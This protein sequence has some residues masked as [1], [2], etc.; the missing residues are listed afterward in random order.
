MTPHVTHTRVQANGITFH[1]AVSGP[2]AAPPVLCL[3]GFPEGWMSWRPVMKQLGHLRVYAPDM[4]GYGDTDRPSCGYDVESLTDDIRALIEALGLDRPVLVGHD[5]GGELGWIFAHRYSAFISRL[6]VVNGTHPRTLVRAALQVDDLQ[7]FRLAFVPFLAVPWL[8]EHLVA[9]PP[10]RRLLKL[11]FT[12]REGRPG[13]MDTALV[14][15]L[16]ARFHTA[17]EARAPI[18][19]YRELL[20]TLILPGRRKR[21]NAIYDT[22]ITVPITQVWGEEDEALSAEVALKADRDAGR[23][24]EWR[25]LPGVGHFVS[26]EAP[27]K[28][29]REIARVVPR[30]AGSGAGQ[31][32][33]R[34]A[35]VPGRAAS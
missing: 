34:Q 11:S 25:P 14:D 10:G 8:P 18:E 5:W 35:G 12:I 15:E 1:V 26:L 3:H 29:A 32:R 9:T 4:R 20:R 23:S 13:T 2:K 21:L 24:V 17:A 28:L 7:T 33:R 6:V 31:R 27:D 30:A 22:P 16:V 19:Y